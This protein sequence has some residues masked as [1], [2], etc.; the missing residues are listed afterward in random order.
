MYHF[1]YRSIKEQWGSFVNFDND[2]KEK[3]VTPYDSL[4]GTTVEVGTGTNANSKDPRGVSG[5][6]EYALIGMH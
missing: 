3:E 2:D 6:C 4:G 1:A 5:H